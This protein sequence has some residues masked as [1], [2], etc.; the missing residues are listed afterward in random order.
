[1]FLGLLFIGGVVLYV[2]L[3]QVL[4]FHLVRSV[5]NRVLQKNKK[6][7]VILS[8]ADVANITNK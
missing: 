1:M 4:R 5:C 8:E 7:N 2:T 3:H 6:K